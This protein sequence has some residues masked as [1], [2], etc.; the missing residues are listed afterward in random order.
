[1]CIGTSAGNY[2]HYSPEL[3]D[4]H[5]SGISFDKTNYLMPWALHMIPPSGLITTRTGELTED[6]RIPT[7]LG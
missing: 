4:N 7:A 2:D 1:M 6:A 5:V 3:K